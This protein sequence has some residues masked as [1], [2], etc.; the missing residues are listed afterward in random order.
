MIVEK[1]ATSVARDT[2]LGKNDK[3]DSRVKTFDHLNNG[4]RVINDIGRLHG[5]NSSRDSEISV[6][7]IRTL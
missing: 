5:R 3:V 6:K 7:H 1:I 4:C 2:Q